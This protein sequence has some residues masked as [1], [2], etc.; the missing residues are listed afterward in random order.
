MLQINS[1]PEVT[2]SNT[3]KTPSPEVTVSENATDKL[4]H[5]S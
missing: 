3:D 5:I 4:H 1:I 2:V